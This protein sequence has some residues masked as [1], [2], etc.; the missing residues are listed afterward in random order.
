M[1]RTSPNI[2]AAILAG[3]WLII[4]LALPLFA[5]SP[6]GVGTFVTLGVNGVEAIGASGLVLLMLIP[7]LLMLVSSLLWEKEVGLIISGISFVATLVF[8]L[9]CGSGICFA[10]LDQGLGL[11]LSGFSSSLGKAAERYSLYRVLWGAGGILCLILSAGVFVAELLLGD[12]SGRGKT[13]QPTND[14]EF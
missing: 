5:I 11:G 13:I 6:V 3:L 14:F 9:A 1:R 10:R 8:L 7:G 12:R 4:F 2:V